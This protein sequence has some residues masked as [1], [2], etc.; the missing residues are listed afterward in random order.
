M[1]L[2]PARMIPARI[3]GV[4][5]FLPE[6]RLGNED[7]AQVFETWSADKIYEK[8]GI[9]ERRVAAPDETALDM[10]IKAAERLI[11]KLGIDRQSID[12]LIFCTQAP[13]YILPTSACVMQHRLGLAKT[14]GAF[15]INLGCS[16]YVY[17]LS[18]AAGLIAGGM[19]ERILFVTAD[20]YS[21]F[22]N[23]NDRSV[24]TL[25]GD[26]ASATLI[27]AGRD[28]EDASIGP[29]IFG[30]DGSGAEDLIVPSG[31]ARQPRTDDTARELEDEF[32]NVRSKDNLYMNGTA[33][34][35]FTLREIPKLLAGLKDKSGL[36]DDDIDFYVLHQANRFML[37][38]LVK[39]MKIPPA[40]APYHFELIG[41][42]VSSTIPFVL[43]ALLSA[44]KIRPGSR[45]VLMGFGVGLS[46]GGTVV[47]F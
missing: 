20:T 43:E 38:A 23:E 25:F 10:G 19:A 2:S 15:D 29:F 21:K 8:T 11:E 18:I 12:H 9:M 5:T 1:A 35:S 26:G 30:T 28:S 47:K 45:A 6:K 13:D 4:A 34:M 31:G 37:D 41:N 46:W 27:E 17:G 16:G 42:T 22:I 44:E 32:G 14:T 3:A 36:D 40:K 7:L 39:K 33:V 24:R